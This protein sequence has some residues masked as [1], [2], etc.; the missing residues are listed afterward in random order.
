MPLKL[1][2]PANA[3]HTRFTVTAHVTETWVV[4]AG[5]NFLFKQGDDG[6]VVHEP[7][8]GDLYECWICGAEAKKERV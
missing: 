2:C 3:D 1:T 6:E 7:D 5:S 4:D 8:S